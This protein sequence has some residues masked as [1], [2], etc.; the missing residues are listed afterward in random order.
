M[1]HVLIDCDPGS[2]DA[3]AIMAAL[4]SPELDVVGLTTVGGNAR[5]GDTTKNALAVLETIGRADLPVWRGA[6]SPLEGTFH[7]GYDFHGAAGIGVPLPA[8]KTPAQAA[9]ASQAIAAAALSRPGEL[10]LIAL[11]PL[12]NVALALRREP[13][14]AEEV[15]EIVV[16]GGAVQAPGNV[17][18]HAEFNIYND[19]LAAQSVLE[20]GAPI[21][22]VGLDVT[23]QAAVS[24]TDEPWIEG[25]SATA[26]LARRMLRAWFEG[27][28]DQ[29]LYGLHDPLAV[30]AAID[31]TMLSYRQGT[32][33]VETRD[34]ERLGRTTAA[35]GPGPVRIALDIDAP[36][37]VSAITAR[38]R[39][40]R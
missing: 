1:K 17:T 25:D 10:T 12:T 16:M 28:L 11:G 30:A 9:P 27:H 29:D 34:P 3:L 26:T 39:G 31:P 37:A 7:Y 40:Q 24:R 5:I 14:L 18:P 35:Y 33:D 23:M 21:T 4:N 36:T 32:I 13:R 20:S 8:P 38:I 6:A 22:L 2:D 15:A 19:P